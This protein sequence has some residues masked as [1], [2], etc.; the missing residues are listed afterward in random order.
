MDEL[1]KMLTDREEE[2]RHVIECARKCIESGTGRIAA[3]LP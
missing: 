1:G 2:L 3:R